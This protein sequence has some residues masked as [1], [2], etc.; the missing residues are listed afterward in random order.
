MGLLSERGIFPMDAF[1]RVDPDRLRREL[2]EMQAYVRRDPET[3]GSL[4]H[5][6]VRWTKP[7]GADESLR[8]C[9][10]SIWRAFGQFPPPKYSP[11]V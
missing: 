11:F 4:T 6:E 3:A 5:K 9:E 2:P 10:P 8:D 7:S 1:V